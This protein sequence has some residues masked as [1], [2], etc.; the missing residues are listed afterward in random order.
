VTDG[1]NHTTVT[2]Y[3]DVG[4]ATKVTYDDTSFSETRYGVGNHPV[5]DSDLPD[6]PGDFPTTFD[7]QHVV[8]VAQHASTDGAP[9]ITHYLYDTAGRLTDVWERLHDN[10]NGTD[11]WPHWQYTYDGLGNQASITDPKGHVTQ[12]EDT[13]ATTADAP[14]YRAGRTKTHTRTLPAVGGVTVTEITTYDALGRT[15]A[16]EDFKGQTTAYRYDDSPVGQGRVS[17]EYRFAIGATVLRPLWLRA[18]M[19]TSGKPLESVEF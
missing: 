5:T 7:G 11:S 9:A 17:A 4:R 18:K 2:D 10:T 6:L 3:D 19:L 12:F 8:K 15:L 14:Y 16:V 13:Y 1:R